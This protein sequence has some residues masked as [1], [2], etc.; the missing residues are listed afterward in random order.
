MV[1][2]AY[3]Y[4]YAWRTEALL[5]VRSIRVLYAIRIVRVYTTSHPYPPAGLP[6]T[7]PA[8]RPACSPRLDTHTQSFIAEAVHELEAVGLLREDGEGGLAVTGAMMKD[9][10]EVRERTDGGREGW[11]RVIGSSVIGL[12]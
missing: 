12:K 2:P 1:D 9:K 10:A 6:C 7:H 8:A 5:H 4:V 11:G 3:Q